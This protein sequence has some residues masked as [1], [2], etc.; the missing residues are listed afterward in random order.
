M[1]GGSL[2]FSGADRGSFSV[3]NTGVACFAS[4]TAIR[5]P[6]GD[7]AI[8]D[9]RPGDLLCLWDGPPEAV[10]WAGHTDLTLKA[11]T[12]DASQT[13]VRIKPQAG[14]GQRALVVS[15]QH[16][17]LMRLADGTTMFARAR[18]LAEETALASYAPGRTSITY[19]HLLLA[20]HRVLIAEGRPSESFYPGPYALKLMTPEARARVLAAASG[21]RM[22]D[23]RATY[24]R[25]AAVVLGRRNVRKLAAAGQLF[26]PDFPSVTRREDFTR[27]SVVA[28]R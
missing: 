4:G 6:Q 22:D 25:R 10:I 1:S 26:F 8:E 21:L 14:Q 13:P 23:P 28:A 17:M 27:F 3:D 16:C 9:L 12:T 19:H 24:G 11:G 7:V 5:T 18:H 2:T 20:R 15:P